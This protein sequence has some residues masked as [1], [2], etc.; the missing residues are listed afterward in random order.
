MARSDRPARSARVAWVSPAARRSRRSSG[1]YLPVFAGI[2]ALRCD[3]QVDPSDPINTRVPAFGGGN[4]ITWSRT[5]FPE[6]RGSR[7]TESQSPLS[8][9]QSPSPRTSHTQL[10]PHCSRYVAFAAELRGQGAARAVRSE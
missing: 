3:V 10:W 4:E 1:P 6:S 8:Q 7:R 5:R 9:L 2:R